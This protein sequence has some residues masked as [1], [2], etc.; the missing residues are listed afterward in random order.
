MK[1]LRSLLIGLVGSLVLLTTVGADTILNVSN[2]T[3]IRPGIPYVEGQQG[4]PYPS[5]NNFTNNPNIK[6]GPREGDERVFL[7]GKHCPGGTAGCKDGYYYNNPPSSLKPNDVVRFEIYFHNNGEDPYDDGGTSSPDATN[8]EV[9]ID[10]N[11]IQDP[12][13]KDLI[14]PKGFITADNNEYRTDIKNAN[15][16]IKNAS[17]NTEKIATDDMQ[18][19]L[20][21]LGLELELVQDSTWLT[22]L[23]GKNDYFDQSVKSAT[24]ITIDTVKPDNI[25]IKVTPK[26][27]AK[28]NKIWLHFDKLPGC[29]RYSGFVYFD[30][31]V[32]KKEIPKPKKCIDLQITKQESATINNK[33]AI[34][35]SANFSLENVTGVEG[36]V[37]WTST[38]PNGVFYKSDKITI[39]GTGSAKT[40]KNE[41]VYYLGKGEV[42]ATASDLPAD[43]NTAECTAKIAI[44]EKPGI[45]KDLKPTKND[46]EIKGKKAHELSATFTLENAP[47]TTK[48]MIHWV[49]ADENAVFLDSDKTTELGTGEA[50]SFLDQKIYYLSDAKV[51]AEVVDMSAAKNNVDFTICKAKLEFPAKPQVCK[52]LR[53]NYQKEI[54]EGTVSKFIAKA[55]DTEGK[56]FNGKITY[57]VDPQYGTFY[58][59]EPSG[60]VKNTSPEVKEYD[61]TKPIKKPIGG[62]CPDNQK[63]ASTG[64]G[65]GINVTPEA[66]GNEA[67]AKPGVSTTGLIG[68]FSGANLW[69]ADIGSQIEITTDILNGDFLYKIDQQELLKKA[70]EFNQYIP[71]PAKIPGG[72]TDPSPIENPKNFGKTNIFSSDAF[73]LIPSNDPNDYKLQPVIDQNELF[74]P[75]KPKIESLFP[76]YFKSGSK[77]TVDPGTVV[78]F[79]AKKPGTNVIKISTECTDKCKREFSIKPAQKLVCEATTFTANIG[80]TVVSKLKPGQDHLLKAEF[81]YDAAKTQKIPSQNVEVKWTTTDPN[82]LFFSQADPSTGHSSGFVGPNVVKYKGSGEVKAEL[83]KVDGKVVNAPLCKASIGPEKNICVSMEIVSNPTEPLEVGQESI[84][85]IF[86]KDSFGNSLPAETK[87]IWGTNTDGTLSFGNKNSTTSLPLNHGDQPV[88]FKGSQKEGTVTLKMDPTDPLYSAACADAI[89]VVKKPVPAVCKDLTVTDIVTGKELQSELDAGKIYK[90]K[91]DATYSAAKTGEK[92]T[93]KIEP[94]YVYGAF[95]DPNL[96]DLTKSGIITIFNNSDMSQKA[97]LNQIK[98]GLTSSVEVADGTEVTLL[99]FKDIAS[100]SEVLTIKASGTTEAACENKYSIKAPKLP[101]EIECIDLTI[102]TPDD[103][104]DIKGKKSQIFS[105]TV[106]PKSL[107]DDLY[108]NWM[109]TG[110]DGEWENGKEEYNDDK[111]GDTTNKLTNFSKDIEVEV[112]ASKTANGSK[113][114]KCKDTREAEDV[115]KKKPTIKKL[116]YKKGKIKKADDLINVSDKDKNFTYKII[117]EANKELKSVKIEEEKLNNWEI[118]GS[119]GGSLKFSGMTINV[120]D[121]NDEYTILRTDDYDRDD[122]DKGFNTEDDLKDYEDE[123]NC[124]DAKNKVCIV[125]NK[126]ENFDDIV[127]N[128]AD[129][130]AIEFENISAKTKIF[131]KFQVEN[132]TVINSQKCK[133]LKPEDGCGES[134]P[135]R[136]SFESIDRDNEKDSGKDNA[137]VIAICPFILTRQAGDVFFKDV[138]D[139]GID[140]SKC[141]DVKTTPGTVIKEEKVVKVKITKTGTGQLSDEAIQLDLPSH[142]VCRYSNLSSNIEGYNDVLSN[143]SSTICEFSAEVAEKWQETNIRDAID[144]NITKI[145]RWGQNITSDLELKNMDQLKTLSNHESGIFVRVNGDLTIGDPNSKEDIVTIEGVDTVPAAQTYIVKNGNLHI[146]SNIIYGTTNYDGKPKNIPSAAF[147]VINGDIIIDNDVTQIDGI[148]MAVKYADS[149]N[150]QVMNPPG[151][152][153]TENKLVINGSLIGDVFDLFASRIGIGDPTSDE[154]SVTIRHDARILLNTPPGLGELINI[155]QAIVPN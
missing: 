151:A 110:G 48:P 153:E 82:G 146:K 138:F 93:Y 66:G 19:I 86:S 40:N 131:I 103:D 13:I 149:K 67:A 28:N 38:D 35:L 65:S 16:V 87:V 137:E 89:V 79:V 109:V 116:V 147:I 134:F 33:E 50:F 105:V 97:I 75:Y 115:V 61:N 132:N 77:I 95:I 140:V 69:G 150:G 142:D 85:R 17:G 18:L 129:G 112:Y 37:Q 24:S 155:Q 36:K 60:Q 34:G 88:N 30:A 141:A 14:R 6:A 26:F 154:G 119:L 136:V 12:T 32:I 25:T 81:F 135:N 104:W 21:E 4:L 51:T 145:A 107:E 83:V 121:G 52:D 57:S 58:T 144:A 124:K 3:P 31:K 43:I 11:N 111:K 68:T 73:A 64:T 106:E 96:G 78:Y 53:V 133:K 46:V 59:Y 39:L 143:F 27:D 148:L 94:A 130:K 114:E 92:V 84:L 152:D 108:Y 98:T 90:L 139:T 128:F 72:Y 23:K 8:V 127:A 5:F 55:E 29:F 49:S 113:I 126:K 74:N 99:V 62:F 42:T 117:F 9:G 101:E 44:E 10:L 102:T 22:M 1:R 20:S 71:G 100:V 2:Y 80:K 123:Y 125:L 120:D 76:E 122:D 70:E 54:V 63:V 47:K 15:T 91:A 56:D 118:P 45:C 41:T 7:V